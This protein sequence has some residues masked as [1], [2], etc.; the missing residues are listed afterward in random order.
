MRICL[1]DAGN[2][3]GVADDAD[4]AMDAAAACIAGGGAA[5]VEL[6]RLVTGAGL[7][8]AYARL[9]AGWTGRLRGGRVTWT[10]DLPAAA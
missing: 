8:P 3:C 4:R 2:R 1:W 10:P 5:R 7:Q 6:A 9:G